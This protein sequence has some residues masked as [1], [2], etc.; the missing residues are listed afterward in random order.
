MNIIYVFKNKALYRNR[1]AFTKAPLY[2]Y[3][4]TPKVGEDEKV[5]L[6]K[7]INWEFEPQLPY[8]VNGSIA[9][10]MTTTISKRALILAK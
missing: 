3:L 1:T 8:R 10:V 4:L 5:I 6:K 9:R 2:E 7:K